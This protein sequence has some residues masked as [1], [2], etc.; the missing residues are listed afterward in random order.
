[1]SGSLA[2]IA[3]MVLRYLYILRSSWPRV[4]ELAYWPT[5]QMIL[6]GFISQYFMTQS[7]LLGQ[8]TGLLVS[9]VLLWDVLF[10]AQL[11][12][13]VVFFEELH[14]RNLGHLFVSPLQPL[15]LVAALMT[16][17]L[18]RTLIGVGSA[19]TLAALFYGTYLTDLGLALVAFLAC[20]MMAGWSV[21]LLVTALVLRHGVG[22][23]SI[24]WVAIFALAPVSGIY[25]PI[26]TLPDW[27]QPVAWALPSAY[28]FEGMRAALLDNTVRLDYLGYALGLNGLYL[29]IGVVVF[30]ATFRLARQLG[31]LLQSGE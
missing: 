28:V 27:L 10:R 24:A 3:A 19:A 4:L 30:L 29:G 9:G 12:F 21:G 20:L 23:E 14:S 16:I 8:A 1:M 15:E 22:A 26:A 7:S 11:G 6:W 18:I 2:R 25:Y 13:S 31:L 5:V 17:S